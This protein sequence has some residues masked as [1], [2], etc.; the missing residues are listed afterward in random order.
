MFSNS[1]RHKQHGSALIVSLFVIV[2]MSLLAA[3]MI[4]VDWANQDITTKEVLGTRAWF[5]AHSANEVTL[6][7]LFPLNQPPNTAACTNTHFAPANNFHCSA[8][9]ACTLHAVSGAEGTINTFYLVSTATCGSGENQV[10][11]TQEAW[12]KEIQ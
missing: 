8:D 3:A 6:S 1:P 10:S 7:E 2:V 12:A 5:T 11:R 9:V 4:R